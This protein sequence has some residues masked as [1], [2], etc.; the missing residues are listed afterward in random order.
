LFTI[1]SILIII[2]VPLVFL[3]FIWVFEIYA[4]SRPTII[5]ACIVWGGLAAAVAYGIT[6]TLLHGSL[7]YEQAVLFVAPVRWTG[8][9]TASRWAPALPSS[10]T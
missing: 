8:R 9:S 4:L 1:L 5:A 3:Y 2:A 6:S 10:K 7:V